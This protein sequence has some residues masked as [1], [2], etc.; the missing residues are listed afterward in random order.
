MLQDFITQAMGEINAPKGDVEQGLG[1]LLSVVKQ[2]AKG[3]DFSALLSAIPGA[4]DLLKHYDRN[5]SPAAS[6][7]S[8]FMG[9]MGGLLGG[10]SAAN[11]A[12]VAALLGQL[13]L[14]SGQVGTLAKLFIDYAKQHVSED[15]INNLMGDLGDFLGKKVA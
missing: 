9:A 10:S 3:A 4:E 14:D 2:Q 6:L 8:G 11:L 12:G 7:S 5:S 13:N 15:V 1:G